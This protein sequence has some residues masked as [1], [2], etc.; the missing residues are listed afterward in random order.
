MHNKFGVLPLP[1]K[2]DVSVHKFHDLEFHK[3]GRAFVK[4]R[5]DTPET[6][7]SLGLQS[8]MFDPIGGHASRKA[9]AEQNQ[10][11]QATV[12]CAIWKGRTK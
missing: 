10:V 1:T 4:A 9:Y 2:Q 8:M 5:G 3:S 6:I 7:R 11:S 12:S